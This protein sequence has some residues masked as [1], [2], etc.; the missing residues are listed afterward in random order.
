M[1]AQ[2]AVRA[3]DID[4]MDR[5]YDTVGALADQLDQPMLNWLHSHNCALRARL[6]G[7]IEQTEQWAAKAFEIGTDSGQPDARWFYG[8]QMVAAS[9]DRGTLGEMVPVLEQLAA[10]IPDLAASLAPGLALAHVE[11][12]RLGDA[13]RLLEAFAATNF[14][15]A[16]EQ[17]WLYCMTQYADVAIACR[18]PKYA[19]PLF[20]RLAPYPDQLSTTGVAVG[21]PVSHFLGGLATVLGRYDEADAYFTHAAA[22]NDRANAKCFAART[23]LSWGTMLTERNA[24]GDND[25]ARDLLTTAQTAAAT[26]GYANIQR[27][28]TEALQHLD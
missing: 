10:D 8:A 1:R 4:E 6:A 12:G 14:D 3:G 27:H 16:M 20:D 19:G 15:L 25:R 24:P 11:A 5:C 17:M 7:D 26:H 18:D 13:R 2:A 28:A 23:N 21:G 22:F 9:F